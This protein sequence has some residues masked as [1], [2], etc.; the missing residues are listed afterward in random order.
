MVVQAEE[1]EDAVTTRVGIDYNYVRLETLF[2]IS[3]LVDIQSQSSISNKF[4]A[5][6]LCVNAHSLIDGL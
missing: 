5:V 4:F 6:K 1:R 3:R 2:T